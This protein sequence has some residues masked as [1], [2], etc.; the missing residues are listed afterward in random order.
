[1][2]DEI[3]YALLILGLG[4]SLVV[5]AHNTFATKTVVETMDARIYEIWKE[6]VKKP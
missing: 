1:M 4:M 6:V 5:Y 2:K 3:K